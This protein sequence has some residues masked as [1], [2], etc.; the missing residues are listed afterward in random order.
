[1]TV[2]TLP[3]LNDFPHSVLIDIIKAIYGRHDDIDEIVD[4]HVECQLHRDVKEEREVNNE[5][6]SSHSA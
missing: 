5:G 1:M 4:T 2:M 3:T 6:D